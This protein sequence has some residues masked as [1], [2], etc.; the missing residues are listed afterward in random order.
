MEIQITT[1]SENT[2]GPGNFLGEWGL[3]ILVEA[4]GLKLL[5]D[6]GQSISAVHNAD[7]FGIDLGK[8]D[9]VILSHGHYDHTGGLRPVLARMKKR[10]EIIAHPDVWAAKYARRQGRADRY[11]GIP[12]RRNE[13]ESLGACFKEEKGPTRITDTIITSGEIPMVTDF[14][15]IPP[16]LQVK[17]PGG[18]Q[19]D[20]LLDDQ[21][22]ILQT[23]A[24]LVV[25]LG[26]AHRGIINTLYHAQQ[27]T[28][29]KKI[30]AVLG[31]CHL[32]N[33]PRERVQLT[34]NA[35]KEMGVERLGVCHCTGLPAAGIMA[36]EF[37]KRFFFNTAGT[38][39]KLP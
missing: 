8:I 18:F 19:P 7:I 17:T 26:C 12:Y 1:L 34:V 2:A 21:A 6:C 15:G 24:G 14:E 20:Q 3:S 36:Q 10:I 33:A 27:L 25:I 39:I 4:E 5:L 11:I 37:G 29:V 28:G 32:S 31:G 30:H 35:L 22:M 16:D 23:G 38:V 9:K 13:M